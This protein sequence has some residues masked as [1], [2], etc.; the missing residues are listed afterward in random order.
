MAHIFFEK[1]ENRRS[2]QSLYSGYSG[3]STPDSEF[4]LYYGAPTPISE[5]KKYY[6]FPLPYEYNR[7]S[8]TSWYPW[9]GWG[10]YGYGYNPYGFGSYSPYNTLPFWNNPITSYTSPWSS[11][12]TNLW[13]SVNSFLSPLW[14]ILGGFFGSYPWGTYPGNSGNTSPGQIVPLYAAQ[15]PSPTTYYG[16]NIPTPKTIYSPPTTAFGPLYG[17]SA[18]TLPDTSYTPPGSTVW[19]LYGISLPTTSSTSWPASW[20]SAL[21][22]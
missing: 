12:I 14:N 5:L 7:I 2:T 4:R 20:P 3:Y 18:P 22:Y 21:T 9:G 17:I 10:G 15:V 8:P 19:A 1:L 16:V 13:G 11:P 6:E